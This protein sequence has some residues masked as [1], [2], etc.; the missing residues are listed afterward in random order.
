[1]KKSALDWL[2]CPSCGEAFTLENVK[3]TEGDEIMDAEL[4]CICRSYS[5][6][7]GVPRLLPDV[8]DGSNWETADRFG[9]EWNQFDMITDKYEKQFLSW[10][11]PVGPEYFKDKSILDVGCGKGRHVLQAQKFGASTV[12]GIDL[13]QAVEAAFKNVGRLPN[14]HIVQADLYSL[15][16]K[17]VFDYAFS[18]GVLHHTPNPAKSF[19]CM[20]KKVKQGGGVSAWVYGREGND[21]IIYL[22]N[23]IRRITSKLPLMITKALAFVV[24][25]FLQLLLVLIYAP[26]K[27]RNWL[28]NTLPY[29]DYL[30]HISEF[31]FR[32][33]YSI[34]FDHLLPEI[35]F[36]IKKEEFEKWFLDAH[37]ENVTITRRN[38]NSW[39]GFGIK[40]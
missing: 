29:S 26:A 33:N 5:V 14:V 2:C 1:M 34:V 21:W 37:L 30:C 40:N 39:R 20:A 18:I 23:P 3:K 27:N 24:S 38:K 25:I 32:E 28:K 8:I 35:A 17:S 9:Q 19:S 12:F 31:S 36:Y 7:R 16:F 4:R 10:I 11:E 13:S 15:P 22:L 6:I